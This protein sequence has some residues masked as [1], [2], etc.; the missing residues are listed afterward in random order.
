MFS[1]MEADGVISSVALRRTHF[2]TVSWYS[3]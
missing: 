1:Q 2:D 3:M